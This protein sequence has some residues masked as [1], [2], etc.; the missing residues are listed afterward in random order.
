MRRAVQSLELVVHR[1]HVHLKQL[2][3]VGDKVTWR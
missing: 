1:D 2:L 3:K